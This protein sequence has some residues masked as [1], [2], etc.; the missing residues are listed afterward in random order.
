MGSPV[1]TGGPVTSMADVVEH[2]QG[3]RRRRLFFCTRWLQGSDKQD[4]R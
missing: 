4:F 3:V 1:V 2:P